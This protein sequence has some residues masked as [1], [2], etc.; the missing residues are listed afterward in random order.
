MSRR[1]R[2]RAHQVAAVNAIQIAINGSRKLDAADVAGMKAA[3][4]LALR[5]LTRGEEYA[6]AWMRL[7]DAANM[8]ETL[9]AMRIGAG[10][11]ADAVIEAAQ[12]ALA[13]IHTRYT[14]RGTRALYADEIDALSWLVRLHDTQLSEVSYREFRDAFER[15]KQRIAQA[16]AGN[17]APGVTVIAGSVK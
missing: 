2:A 8:A 1:A 12:A 13:E 10:D 14:E 6:A 17:V 5:S 11:D 16:Q 4:A 3:H 9:A 15:T 7:A